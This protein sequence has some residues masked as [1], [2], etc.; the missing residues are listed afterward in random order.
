MRF[1]GTVFKVEELWSI[2]VPILGVFTQGYTKEDAF[3]MIR[4]A[5]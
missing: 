3:D 4:D 1:A 5:I 2:E